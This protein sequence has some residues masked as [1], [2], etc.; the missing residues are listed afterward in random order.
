MPD[1]YGDLKYL[2]SGIKFDKS[3]DEMNNFRTHDVICTPAIF[4][5]EVI[6]VVQVINSKGDIF[7]ESD[8]LPLENISRFIAYALYH[9]RLYDELATFKGLEKEKAEFRMQEHFL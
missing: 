4:K 3:W 8:I 9:A 2:D 5:G 7:H 1:A 6:G